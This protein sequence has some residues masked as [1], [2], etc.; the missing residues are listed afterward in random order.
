MSL[1][2]MVE[3]FLWY[4]ERTVLLWFGLFFWVALVGVLNF[5]KFKL[6]RWKDR[7]LWLAALL[8]GA[9]FIGIPAHYLSFD[10]V[11]DHGELSVSVMSWLAWRGQQV[12]PLIDS[13][14]DYANFYG[15]ITYFFF[16]LFPKILGPSFLTMKTP[17]LILPAFFWASLYWM[18]RPFASRTIAFLGASLFL[19]VPMMFGAFY[20]WL[21]PDSLM[22]ALAT[23]G[24]LVLARPDFFGKRSAA[25]LCL[26]LLLGFAINT[27]VQGALYFIPL[28][29]FVLSRRGWTAVWIGLIASLV[30]IA[31]PFLFP[32]VS[33]SGF[34][35]IL[36]AARVQGVEW[37]EALKHFF[38]IFLFLLVPLFIAYRAQSKDSADREWEIRPLDLGAFLFTGLIASVISAKPG[39]GYYQLMPLEPAIFLYARRFFVSPS[40][41]TPKQRAAVFAAALTALSLLLP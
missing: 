5:E 32:W 25:S 38:P 40:L 21:R 10:R 31:A 24:C 39:A 34:W 14:Y 20:Y 11:M 1:K 36:D 15:P 33:F 22:L 16:G 9:V 6:D 37:G 27:K 8:V 19:L 41:W 12:Y 4:Q 3:T 35:E 30:A 18:L 13:P 28:F 7:V 23:A 17:C 26:G 2:G 29:W